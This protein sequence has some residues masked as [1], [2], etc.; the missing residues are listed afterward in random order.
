MSDSSV[1][2]P[3]HASALRELGFLT[4]A[5]GDLVVGDAPITP[6]LWV[7]GT[8]VLRTSVL[9]IWADIVAGHLACFTQ[10]P[11][12]PITLDLDVH[13][14]RQPVGTGTVTAAA[15]LVKA[16]R[17][18]VVTRIDLTLDDE[19]L[20]VGGGSFMVSPDPD[21]LAPGGFDV[22]SPGPRLH[23][24]VPFAERVGATQVAPGVA[25]VPRRHETMNATGSLQGG[26]VALALEEAVLAA[27]PRTVLTSIS[28]RYLKPYPV[29]PARA[30]V[31]LDR[32][33]MVGEVV[34]AG[35]GKLGSW[36]TAR[37]EPAAA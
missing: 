4:R 27:E 31:E 34:D 37:Y 11:R 18:V 9:A 10:L 19:P 30:T 13:L 28:V 12:I 32:G 6:E 3:G 21:H 24:S 22:N 7:P 15:S 14:Y 35:T 2:S 1:N 33:L 17:S 5:E 25:E 16:G 23:M 29:G 26:L 36:A 20:G 8:Q